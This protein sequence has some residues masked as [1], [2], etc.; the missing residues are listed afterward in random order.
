RPV[1]LGEIGKRRSVSAGSVSDGF[2]SAVADASGSDG[3]AFGG[4]HRR[5]AHPWF[6]LGL[7]LERLADVF[8]PFAAH[9]VGRLVLAQTDEDRDPHPAVARPFLE[10]DFTDELGLDPVHR[11]VG[12]RL[13]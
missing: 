6:L 8:G 12:L 13:L 11:G 10:G 1:D 4:F 5:A 2:T 9:R 7:L 3:P